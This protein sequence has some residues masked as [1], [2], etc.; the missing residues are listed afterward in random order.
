MPTCHWLLPTHAS[1]LITK[2]RLGLWPN[3]MFSANDNQK[4]GMK[5]VVTQIQIALYIQRAKLDTRYVNSKD[6][7]YA[8]KVNP[9]HERTWTMTWDIEHIHTYFH[10]YLVQSKLN[11]RLVDAYILLAQR[12][13]KR[14]KLLLSNETFSP[15]LTHTT[16]CTSWKIHKG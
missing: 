1:T 7:N 5:S 10:C 16:R 11:N 12:K 6:R 13:S 14:W 2:E 15:T 9:I 4:K 8:N 3:N